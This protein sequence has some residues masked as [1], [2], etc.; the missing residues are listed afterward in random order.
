MAYVLSIG[1]VMRLADREIISPD[2]FETIYK[3]LEPVAEVPIFRKMLINYI[4]WW[5]PHDAASA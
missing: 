4:D 5:M 2:V 1:P 3:P